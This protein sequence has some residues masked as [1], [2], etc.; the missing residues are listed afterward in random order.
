MAEA[1]KNT[2]WGGHREGSGRPA[3]GL[4]KP[5]RLTM[6]LTPE[7]KERI[8]SDAEKAGMTIG[9]FVVSRLYGKD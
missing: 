6:R 5:E 8:Q 9:D 2:G 1:K 3:T 7:E 4:S